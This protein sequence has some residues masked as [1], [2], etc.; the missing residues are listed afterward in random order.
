MLTNLYSFLSTLVQYYHVYYFSSSS[1]PILPKGWTTCS[2]ASDILT[3]QKLSY[4]PDPPIRS[5]PLS[6]T[7][8]GKL[9]KPVTGG[10]VSFTVRLGNEFVSHSFCLLFVLFIISV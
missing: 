3:I 5:K 10:T 8:I 7:F 9:N 6:V 1:G 2:N 4:K